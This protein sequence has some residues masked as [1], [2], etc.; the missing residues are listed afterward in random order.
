MR[1]TA[2]LLLFMFV[3]IFS[4][5][6][7]LVA[8]GQTGREKALASLIEA[9]RSFSR[10]SE[11]KGIREAFL[12][13]LAPDAVVF[14]P[15]PVPGRPVY[16]KM[17]PAS[18]V[19]LTWEPEVAGIASSGELGYTSGP[20]R[21]RPE[22]GAEPTDFGHY[23]SVWKMQTDGTWR[24]F[25]DVGVQHGPQASPQTVT[26]MGPSAGPEAGALSPDDLREAERA[27][28]GK[29]GA[30]QAHAGDRGLRSAFMTF[31]ADDIRSY[32]PGRF[33]LVGKRALGE[34]V[35]SN[36]GR[37]SLSAGGRTGGFFR[38]GI[39]S[40]GDLAFHF[41]TSDYWKDR[42]TMETTAYLM[43]WRKEPS[44][45]WEIVLDIELPVPPEKGETD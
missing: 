7:S 41:G 5:T 15:A 36:A 2:C 3:S 43:I 27:F 18:P 17:N 32:R 37:A 30:F 45:D 33:P 24:V 10:T 13:W 23:V 19:V 20:Y 8:A 16:E 25:L 1:R 6:G 40:S 22:R 14:R 4:P 9:E 38:V 44:G 12:N 42:S 34:L 28:K 21:I 29:V 26:D 39:S 35:P 11:D 31:A